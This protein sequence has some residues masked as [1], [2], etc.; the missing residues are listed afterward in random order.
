[1][2]ARLQDHRVVA[3]DELH[4]A[5]FFGEASGPGAGQDV[6]EVL[7]LA[8]TGEGLAFFALTRAGLVQALQEP[9]GV[10]RYAK[11]VGRLTVERL[12]E[13]ALERRRTRKAVV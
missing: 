9:T 3:V 13:C 8:D 6:S 4:E 11:E 2:E 1:M 5:V 7:G 12:G 10:G